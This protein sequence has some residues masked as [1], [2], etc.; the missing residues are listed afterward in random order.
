MVYNYVYEMCKIMINNI[1]D[2]FMEND[3]Y[4]AYSYRIHH[5]T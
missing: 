1:V 4:Y 5:L 2:F 3:Y